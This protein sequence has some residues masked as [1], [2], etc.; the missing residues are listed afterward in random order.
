M[1]AMLMNF[2]K[3][4][5]ELRIKKNEKTKTKISSNKFKRNRNKS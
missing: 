1:P 3:T 2:W 5:Y 4:K